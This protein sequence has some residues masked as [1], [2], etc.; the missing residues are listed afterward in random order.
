MF[1]FWGIFRGQ[2]ENHLANKQVSKYL[3]VQQGDGDAMKSRGIDLNAQP[4][5]DDE[6]EGD[7]VEIPNQ[8]T[9]LIYIQDVPHSKAELKLPSISG[10]PIID[11]HLSPDRCLLM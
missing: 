4:K 2:K 8:M 5:N 10:S 7:D 1:F 6:V 9:V 11:P 3:K